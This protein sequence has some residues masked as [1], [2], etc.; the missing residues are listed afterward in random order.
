[1]FFSCGFNIEKEIKYPYY[2]I[3]VESDWNTNISI[4]LSDG[5]YEEVIP[6][7]VIEYAN[8]KGYIFAKQQDYDYREFT[9]NSQVN[10]YVLKIGNRSS[11]KMNLNEFKNLL[12]KENILSS[13][14]R[15]KKP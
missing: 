11:K 14:I 7:K 8:I 15:W 1:M 13:D 3:S 5:N 4:K 9:L 6:Y 2:I 10:Y 12:I